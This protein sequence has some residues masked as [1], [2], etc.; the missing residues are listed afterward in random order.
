MLSP[1]PYQ[2]YAGELAAIDL[3]WE[4]VDLAEGEYYDV[5]IRHFVADEPRY[6]GQPLTENRWRVPVEVG[7]GKAN[8]DEFTWWVTIRQAGTNA[9][10]SPPSEEWIFIWK[11]N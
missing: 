8:K 9:P 4:G 7:Y 1:E 6:W 10:L 5:T 2:D 11:P 3:V